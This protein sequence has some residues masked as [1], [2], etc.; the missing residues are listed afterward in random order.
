MAMKFANSIL[1]KKILNAPLT[2]GCYIYRDQAG[3]ILYIGKAVVLR[4]R[5]KNYFQQYNDLEQRIRNMVDRIWDVEFVQADNDDEAFILETNLIK[6]YRPKYNVSKKDDKSYSWIRIDR[7]SDFPIIELVREKHKDKAM[8]VGPYQQTPVIRRILKVLRKSIR[9]RTCTRKIEIKKNKA[10]KMVLRSSDPKPCLYYHL[11]LCDAPCAGFVGRIEYRKNIRQVVLFLE[12]RAGELMRTI[13]KDM[14]KAAG[15]KD[16]EKA[17]ELRDRM[18]DLMYLM[19][20][21]DVDIGTDEEVFRRIKKQKKE[22]AF[23]DFEEFF[24]IKAKPGLR[25]ECYDISNTQGRLAVGSMVVFTDLEPDKRMYR[26]FR[27]KFK[28][29]PD[30]YAML[31]EV[32]RRRFKYLSLTEASKHKNGKVQKIDESFSRSPDLIIVDGGKGQLSKTYKVMK[33]MKIKIP[34][35]GL[36]KRFEE[37]VFIR[38]S[39]GEQLFEMK[40]L[41]LT[42]AFGQTI[43]RLRDETHRFA[44]T[45]HR[46]LRLKEQTRSVLSAIPGV[47]KILEKKLLKSF[48]S[49]DNLKI[50]SPEELNLV[51]KN[52]S[53]VK[54][55][56]EALNKNIL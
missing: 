47:G 42:S 46:K 5:V 21:V 18:N 32:F 27:I 28:K 31:E 52:K 33:S 51:I 49:V 11:G 37:I 34:V 8:Y 4:D 22:Q 36:A 19:Q 48:G 7:S 39:H 15:D 9:Y 54:N 13:K 45:Y 14:F 16:F 55:I 53:T 2:P 41:P 30:D 23:K 40:K 24:Q 26:K 20:K 50:V 12:R 10:G 38:E 35:A 17:A 6:K 25:L 29:T 3:V 56:L 44:I 43:Q 1:K